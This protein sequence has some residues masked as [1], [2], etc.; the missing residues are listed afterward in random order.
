MEGSRFMQR[1]ADRL[2]G[3]AA[4][5]VR[6]PLAAMVVLVL[7]GGAG[8]Q[9]SRGLALNADLTELLPRSFRSVQDLDV[10]RERFGGIG[11]VVVVGRG[12]DAEGRR[13]FAED[14]APRIEQLEGIRFVD[15][16]RETAFFEERALYYLELEDLEEVARRIKERER[17]ERRQKNPMLLKLDD[18]PAPPL[19]FGDIEAK[20]AGSSNRRLSGGGEAYYADDRE[21]LVVLLAKPAGLSADLTFARQIVERVERYLA[22]QDLSDYGPGFEVALTGTYKKKLDQQRQISRDLA[23][24]SSVAGALMFGY[25]LLHFRRLAAVALVLVPVGVGLTWTYGFVALAYGSVNL[26]TAFLG[27]ILGGLGTE[28]GIHILGRYVALREDGL[29]AEAATREAFAHTGVSALVSSFIAALTFLSLAISEFRAFREF[30]I[31]AAVGMLLVFAAYVAAL[32]ALLGLLERFGWRPPRQAR[33]TQQ[34]AVARRLPRLA[35]PV[36][37]AVGLPLLL[38]VTQVP[39]TAFN[40][41]FAALE[42]ASLPSFVL[43]R[44]VNRLLG[45]SQTPTIILTDTAEE[46][47][48][49]VA[50]IQRNRAQKGAK[51]TV[52]FA[53]ALGDLVPTRQEEKREVLA[54]MERTLVRVDRAEL[55]PDV[56]ASYD[57]LLTAVRAEPF[58][59]DDIPASVR[60]QFEGIDGRSEGGFVLVFPGVSMSDGKAVEAFAGELRGLSLPGGREAHA[61]GEAMILA[62]IIDMVSRES[63]PVLG[64]AVVLVILAL[65]L[66][67]GSLREAL[68]CLSPTIVSIVAL[69]GLMATIGLRFNFLNIVAVPVLIGTTVDAGVHLISRLRDSTEHAFAPVFAETG[70]A[71]CGGLIT[72][73]VGFAALTMADHPG[74]WSL[75]TLT[76]LGFAV[77]LV[78]MLLGFPAALLL[79]ASRRAASPSPSGDPA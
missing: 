6:R 56:A 65:W 63:L 18:E 23:V 62:D 41:D 43:D 76:I 9:A 64:A 4:L 74:L 21:Q 3:L 2:G 17:W 53:A 33:I 38:L 40:Y 69:V 66:A 58:E 27:A 54:S 73:A 36:A 51:T 13:R 25:L 5:G 59:R 48:H 24:A 8:F 32:P 30:G 26:L 52:D 49:L 34:S 7:L 61:A 28:H 67:L 42:D 57:Q 1:L 78:V 10:L 39:R 46:E 45:Y 47:R 20:Y 29:G 22:A 72:S 68:V 75:G 19:E 71:I 15:F 77:N 31:I 11:Y 70:R 14:F 55:P 44:K 79:R 37:W 50:Q 12:G 60:R 16:K 35:R